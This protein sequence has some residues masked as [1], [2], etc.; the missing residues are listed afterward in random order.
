MPNSKE[1]ML[2]DI[3]INNNNKTIYFVIN[4]IEL[5]MNFKIYDDNNAK[6]KEENK[7]GRKLSLKERIRFFSGEEKTKK[8]VAKN[9]KP[10]KLVI[11]AM[12]QQ[13]DKS[14]SKNANSDLNNNNYENKKVIKNKTTYKNI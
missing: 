3:I 6:M 4:D 1:I 5:K 10:R 2:D 8:Q 14:L 9:Y 7:E 12:F 13:S 11:P